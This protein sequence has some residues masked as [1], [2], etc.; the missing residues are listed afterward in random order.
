VIK[1]KQRSHINKEIWQDLPELPTYLDDPEFLLYAQRVDMII[2]AAGEVGVTTRE[3]H[4]RL[5][6]RTRREWTMDAIVSLHMID[7]VGFLPT[8]YRKI[9]FFR[10]AADPHPMIR[11][12]R[13]S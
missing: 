11:E 3:I 12:D 2:A 7:T 1:S 4:V 9:G 13:D 10:R 6:E 8:R 5:G